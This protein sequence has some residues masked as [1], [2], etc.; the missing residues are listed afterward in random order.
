MLCG[1]ILGMGMHWTD[2]GVVQGMDMG[3]KYA[4]GGYGFQGMYWVDMGCRMMHWG[5]H[6]QHEDVLWMDIEHW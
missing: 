5:G 3:Q 4:L 6:G 2:M 1:W